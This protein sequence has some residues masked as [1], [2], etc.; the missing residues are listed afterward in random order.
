MAKGFSSNSD[1]FLAKIRKIAQEAKDVKRPMARWRLGYGV[2]TVRASRP[3]VGQSGMFRGNP[4]RKLAP[5]Y[6]RKDGTVVPVW[7]G[8]QKVHG[9]GN[10]KGRKR[11]RGPR[12]KESD[13]QLDKLRTQGL[14]GGWAQAAPLFSKGNKRL[15]I[16]ARQP[17]AERQHKM[18]PF[19]FGVK[20]D[21]E[22]SK[23]ALAELDAYFRKLFGD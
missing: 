23:H 16:S 13:R 20:I 21:K 6:T 1:D 4:W 7:G 19:A 15:T 11:R 9:R 2:R 14:I 10:V 17:Y 22:E 8:V 12:Y 5:M 3:S 18:R